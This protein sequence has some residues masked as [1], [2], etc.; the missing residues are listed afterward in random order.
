MKRKKLNRILDTE[1]WSKKKGVV[2][3][4]FHVWQFEPLTL[5]SGDSK[6]NIYIFLS[7]GNQNKYNIFIGVA[8]NTA[9]YYQ[10]L[11]LKNDVHYILLSCTVHDT[12]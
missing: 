3:K 5:F 7:I 1:I 10:K 11:N 9:S 6:L 8:S 2:G 4:F 12:N